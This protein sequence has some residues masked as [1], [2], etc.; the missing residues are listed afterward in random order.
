[1]HDEVV[2]RFPA[3]LTRGQFKLVT[4]E[5]ADEEDGRVYPPSVADGVM[6]THSL[7]MALWLHDKVVEPGWR[8]Y[9]VPMWWKITQ[10]GRDWV[11]AQNGN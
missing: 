10:T 2:A 4:L 5:S 8:G 3:G 9:D 7:M 6:A 11:A 1:M